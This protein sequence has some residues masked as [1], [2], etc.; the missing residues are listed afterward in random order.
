[1]DTTINW[2]IENLIRTTETGGIFEAH[3]ICWVFQGVHQGEYSG[4]TKFDPN[5]SNDNFIPYEDLQ[6]QQVLNWIWNQISKEEIEAKAIE[7]LEER[8]NPTAAAGVPWAPSGTL[9]S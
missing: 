5:P 1:M 7:V 6:E 8:I 9:T 3:W 4:V 2:H